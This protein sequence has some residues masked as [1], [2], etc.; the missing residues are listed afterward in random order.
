MGSDAAGRMVFARF[1]KMNNTIISSAKSFPDGRRENAMSDLANARRAILA[2]QM[3]K[4]AIIILVIFVRW[5]MCSKMMI[6]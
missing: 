2:R 1:V 6:I 4:K 3:E 5:A